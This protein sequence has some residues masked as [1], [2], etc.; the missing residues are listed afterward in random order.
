VQLRAHVLG[1]A[2]GGGLPQWNCGCVGC[3]AARRGD[4]AIE[5]RRQ[6]SL[7]VSADG[8][9]WFLLN[10]S[11]DVRAQLESF[12]ALHPRGLRDSPLGGV[13]LT[14]GDVDAC[15]GL[16]VLREEHPL[17]V[18]ATRAVER[19]LCEHNALVRTLDRRPGQLTWNRLVLDE[20]IE[21]VGASG[22]SGLWVT[23]VPVPGTVPLHLRGLVEPSREDNVALLLRGAS[24]GRLLYAPCVA[25]WTPALEAAARAAEIVFFDGTFFRDDEL[26]ALGLGTRDAH[27]MGHWPLSGEDGSLRWLA[28]LP[29][30][31]KILVHVNNTNPILNRD[32]QE[33]GELLVAGVE[34]GSDGLEVAL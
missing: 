22:P 24:G 1:S 31:R 11:P 13:V 18:H 29:G 27:A 16:F 25:A 5:P 3:V 33:R 34:V 26:P 19:G 4:A 28:R 7:A 30:R 15:L 2:A 14:C 6:A 9:Q 10:A 12:A 8:A 21:L 17:R 23:A 32:A 20:E